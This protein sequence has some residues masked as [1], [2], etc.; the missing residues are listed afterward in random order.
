[1]KK[2]VANGCLKCN[3]KMSK[4]RIRCPL[5]DGEIKPIYG[6]EGELDFL[7][8]GNFPSL[9]EEDKRRMRY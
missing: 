7:E 4:H 5:C 6:E 8:T 9:S 3:I 1:M 2:V